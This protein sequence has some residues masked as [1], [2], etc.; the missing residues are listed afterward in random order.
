MASCDLLF[1]STSCIERASFSDPLARLLGEVR[2]CNRCAG[3]LPDPPRPLLQCGRGARILIAGQAPGRRA[4]ESGTPFDDPSGERL[5]DW[6]GLGRAEFYDP[7]RIAIL[8]MGFCY[9]GSSKRGDLPPRPEC[10][11]HWR[12]RLLRQLPGIRLTLVLGRHAQA[13]HFPGHRG[14]LGELVGAW[15]QYWPEVLPLPH[16]SPRNR[17]WCAQHPWFETELLPALRSRVAGLIQ[18]SAYDR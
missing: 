8:P 15:R 6:L 1:G 4:R 14:S 5:R 18:E 11:A 3:L 16:P 2:A 7:D 12:N 10:A 9:P 13:W 17:R